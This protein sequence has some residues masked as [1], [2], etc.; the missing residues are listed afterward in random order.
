MGAQT[1]IAVIN[2]ERPKEE[3]IP[4]DEPPAS[5]SVDSR[6][7]GSVKDD[8]IK[9]AAKMLMKRGNY[10]PHPNEMNLPMSTPIGARMAI[11]KEHDKGDE[12]LRQ[13]GIEL[14]A[15]ADRLPNRG[16]SGKL[17]T[18]DRIKR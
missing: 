9:L 5:N 6:S 7:A 18:Y 4:P 1:M 11:S 14:R 15:L 13:L 10:P 17:S 3:I 8:L 2:A 12:F 16:L